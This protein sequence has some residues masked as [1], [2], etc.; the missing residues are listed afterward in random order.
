MYC[1][2]TLLA[3][4]DLDSPLDKQPANEPV[5]D[6]GSGRGQSHDERSAEPTVAHKR[7]KFTGSKRKQSY[8]E[9]K[10][11]GTFAPAPPRYATAI[12]VKTPKPVQKSTIHVE[13]AGAGCDAQVSFSFSPAGC[14]SGFTTPGEGELKVGAHQHAANL[15]A[16]N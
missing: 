15:W 13:L 3:G 11:N 12:P 7:R 4:G 8:Y 2:F 1:A 9:K 10:P 16:P 5:W 6:T 14:I